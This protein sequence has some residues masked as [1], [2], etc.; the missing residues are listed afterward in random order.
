MFRYIWISALLIVLQGSFAFA[1]QPAGHDL[2][3]LN[4]STSALKESTLNATISDT[5]DAAPQDNENMIGGYRINKALLNTQ[6]YEFVEGYIAR[7][8]STLHNMKEQRKS[9]LEIIEE[10]LTQHGLPK[11]LKYLAVIESYLNPYARSASGAVG[12]WQFM[13][14]TA[15]NMGLKVS[16]K[17]DERKNVYKSTHAACRYLTSLYGMYG[18]WLLV[19]AA[20]NSGPGYVNNAIKKTGSTDFWEIQNYLPVQS[21][22]HVKKFIATHFLLEGCGSIAT[23]TKKEAAN[24]LLNPSLAISKEDLANSISQQ[25]KGRYNASVI[26]KHLAMD[27]EDFY[28]INPDFDKAIADIGTYEMCLPIHKMDIF[29][30]KKNEILVESIQ[31]LLDPDNK[32]VQENEQSSSSAGL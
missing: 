5:L 9:Y 6:A 29:L 1:G 11:E 31:Q 8:A 23:L 27:M 16:G 19:V 13:T 26:A 14:G 20:Y 10:V 18:D 15:R 21:R 25:I 30:R 12:I 3:V 24:L 7:Y 17:V 22:N 4:D 2:V 28:R 32:S